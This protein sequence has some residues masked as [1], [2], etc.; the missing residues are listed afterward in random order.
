[1]SGI[2]GIDYSLCTMHVFSS[3]RSLIKRTLE[4]F[5]GIIHVGEAN[6]LAPWCSKTP[7]STKCDNSF[8]TSQG[9]HA[10]QH[11]NTSVLVWNLFLPQREMFY[12]DVLLMVHR[13][14]F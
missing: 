5:F 9:E 3:C 12:V 1:M 4:S 6:L 13:T 11:M 7:N 14:M 2:M 8:L 10:L